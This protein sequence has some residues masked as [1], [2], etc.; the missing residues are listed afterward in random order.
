[1]PKEATMRCFIAVTLP[2]AV[3]RQIETLQAGL[4][5][6]GLKMS[7]VRPQNVHLTLKFLG[8]ISP[9]GSEKAQRA[10][11]QAASASAPFDLAMQ[12]MGVFPGIRKPRILWTG[13]GGRTDQLQQVY[14]ALDNGLAAEGFARESRPF[15]AH[16]TLARI[17][18]SL[19]PE[20]LLQAIQETGQYEPGW[21]RVSALVLIKSD[22]R[23]GGAV[24]TVM[25]EIQL[26]KE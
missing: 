17:K 9:A 2:P 22:L 12:G 4:K 14:Q 5:S 26:S 1:M 23:P 15:K 8:D 13:V 10:M 3:L 6:H 20:H 7:W 19:E 16:L 11:L 24:Y 25:R 21:F 18:K